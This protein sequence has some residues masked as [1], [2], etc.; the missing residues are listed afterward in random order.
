M[1][2]S[3]PLTLLLPPHPFL[4]VSAGSLHPATAK[5]TVRAPPSGSSGFLSLERLDP[6]PPRV[7]DNFRLNLRAVGVRGA[8]FSHYYYMVCRR[9]GAGRARR[10]GALGAVVS[11]WARAVKREPLS[12]QVLSRGQIV[13]VGREPRG[14]LTSV[15]VFVDHRLAPAFYFVAFY[16]H[17]GL[18]VAN[19]L[20][21][22][23]QAGACEGKVT[24]GGGGGAGKDEKQ[25]SHLTPPP[26]RRAAGAECGQSQGLSPRGGAEA[27]AAHG[28][29]GPGGPGGCGHGSVRRGRQGPQAPGHGQGL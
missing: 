25:L 3:W 20:R 11:G 5:L 7:G 17:G 23:V 13:S 8:S 27:P 6:Q 12:P 2:G 10:E 26:A 21:V 18:P 19:S 16:Y 9:A 4:Q 28:L 15:S 29:R 1:P 22:D 24:H 14:A